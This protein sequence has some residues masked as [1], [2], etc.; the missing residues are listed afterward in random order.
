MLQLLAGADDE[1]KVILD[2]HDARA[3]LAHYPSVAGH[4]SRADIDANSERV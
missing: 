4:A 3:A 1:F 2:V